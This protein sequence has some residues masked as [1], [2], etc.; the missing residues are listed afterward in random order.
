MNDNDNEP[1]LAKGTAARE[2]GAMTRAAPPKWSV[3]IPVRARAMVL[4][5][6]APGKKAGR[7]FLSGPPDVIGPEDP[8][9]AGASVSVI[10]PATASTFASATRRAAIRCRSPW[11]SART[12]ST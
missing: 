9:A 3:Q 8:L 4:T 7:I 2:R 10:G 6:S 12:R 5:P 1:V 11:R